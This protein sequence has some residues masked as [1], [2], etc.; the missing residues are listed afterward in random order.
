M[1]FDSQI[2]DDRAAYAAKH[3]AFARDMDA[4]LSAIGE[5]PPVT[6]LDCVSAAAAGG[7]V[8][9]REGQYLVYR[10]YSARGTITRRFGGYTTGSRA[11]LA[12]NLAQSA[13]PF[14]ARAYREAKIKAAIFG[15][16]S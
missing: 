10:G 15:G 2:A 5:R 12:L 3:A 6:L 9:L 1:P 4:I 16:A 11:K 13:I 7:G 14:D 8:I